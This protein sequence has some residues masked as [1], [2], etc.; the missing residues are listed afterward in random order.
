MAETAKPRRGKK[1][2][3]IWGRIAFAVA[4]LV[5]VGLIAGVGAF[6]Y[7]YSTTDIPDPNAD[8]QTNTTFIN[9][10]DGTQMGSL[11]VQN[12]VTL[13]YDDM[14][15]VMKDAVVAAENRS[16]WTD[17]GFSVTGMARGAWSIAR[18]G[19][20]QGGSTIT[21]Q[22][23][24]V[25]YLD[26]SRTLTR[27]VRELMLAIKLD[28]EVSKEQILEGYLNTI[29]FGRGAYGIQAASKS[30]F[31]KDAKDLTLSEAAALAAILNNPAAFNPS[32]GD[33][34]R[35]RLLTR[36]QYVLDGMLEEGMISQADYAGARPQLPEFPEVPVSNRYGG[37]NG[38]LIKRVEA[39][40]EAKGIPQDQVQGGGLRVTTTIDKR[41]QD[42]AVEVAQKYT[43]EAAAKGDEGAKPEDLHVALASVDT[44]TGGVLAMYGGPDYVEHPRNWAT[45]PRAAA[46][47]YK[48]FA[49]VAALRQ[50]FD[51][52]TMLNGDTFTPRGDTKPIHNQAKRN[53]GEVTLRESLAKSINTAFVDLTE[54]MAGGPEAIVQAAEDAGAPPL[55]NWEQHSRIALGFNEV[56]PLNMANAYATF[57]NSGER[58]QTHMVAKVEDRHGNVIYEA[59]KKPE[60]TIEPDVA[61][62]VTD[63]L[64]SV[65]DDG[66][67]RSA[68]T[69]D[70]P[71]AGKTGT[72]GID[73][74]ITAA[75]FTGYTKQVSTAVM[76]VAGEGGTGDLVPYR[77]P[78]DRTF[79]ASSY[80][81][82]AWVEYMTTAVEGMPVEDFD[83]PPTPEPIPSPTPTEEPTSEEPSEEPTSEEPSEEP[84]TEEPTEEPTT[85]EPTPEPSEDPTLPSE[86]PTEVPSGPIDTDPPQPEPTG[87]E[88][89]GRGRGDGP[90]GRSSPPPGRGSG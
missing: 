49:T 46:S 21:Q 10:A 15:K 24:K 52:N 38:Y 56:S 58:N 90:P 75:W 85:E 7:L 16:F 50:G 2:K 83:N 81:L 48:A 88:Q 67:G 35:A 54:Q 80:P 79:Y 72:N 74:T 60:Q 28:R 44:A 13:A 89:P 39:E 86:L 70:R 3:S 26:S 32:G 18:G 42:R 66:T 65:V 87:E 19:E 37:P 77:A 33:E 25:M 31:L 64:R 57:A 8:F 1:K 47:T 62:A 53:Y 76:F 27:K 4:T 84:T 34:H 59:E 30:F 20:V 78:G 36:Y 63:G 17:P 40:L 55:D 68:R 69:L 22:Y 5:L 61:A 14:P 29:Y 9:Y 11:S 6:I 23:I 51:L 12:R 71:V 82:S 43:Q 41:M 45:T 73:D